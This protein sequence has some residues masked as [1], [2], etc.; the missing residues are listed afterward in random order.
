MAAFAQLVA[1]DAPAIDGGGAVL[2]SRGE[3][4]AMM[5]R[6]LGTEGRFEADRGV[7]HGPGVR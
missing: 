7:E 3:E 6:E 4:E 2:D 1:A 5:G